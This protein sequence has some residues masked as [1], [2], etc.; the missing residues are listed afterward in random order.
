M[1]TMMVMVEIG[2]DPQYDVGDTIVVP[3]F[4]LFEL[5]LCLCPKQGFIKGHI[6]IYRAP[7]EELLQFHQLK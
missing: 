5:F 3:R 7:V 2:I 6:E 4:T 1:N